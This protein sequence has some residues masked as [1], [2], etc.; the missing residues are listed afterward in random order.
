[1]QV[2]PLSQLENLKAV[3]LLKHYR[4]NILSIMMTHGSREK[5]NRKLFFYL[6]ITDKCAITSRKKTIKK[7]K[8]Y[9]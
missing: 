5:K 2:T 6:I 9:P 7:K 8:G 3:C 1:M 4:T